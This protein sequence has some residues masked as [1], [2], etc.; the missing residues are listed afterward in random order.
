[1]PDPSQQSLLPRYPRS[2][3]LAVGALLLLGLLLRLVPMGRESLRGD[4][5]FTAS[6]TNLSLF[7]AVVAVLRFDV[8][9]PL[10]YLQVNLWSF[11]GH[12]DTWL[13][14]NP[15]F[16]GM[17]TLLLV[18]HI[19]ERRLGTRAGL[20]ALACCAVLGSEM[21]FTDE[22][23]PY[24]MVS[25]LM[26]LSWILADRVRA[27][28]RF[29]TA[30]PLMVTLIIVGGSHSFGSVETSAALLYIAPFGRPKEQ[31]RRELP[32]WLGISALVAFFTLPWLANASLR[33]VGHMSTVNLHTIVETVGGWALGYG[34]VPV[35]PELQTLVACAIALIV[36]YAIRRVPPLQRMILC[37]LLWVLTFTAVA[38]VLWKPIWLF[39]P[40]SYCAP[41][42]AIVFGG[43]ANE[44]FER[45]GRRP[46]AIAQ[47][48]AMGGVLVILLAMG[49]FSV[50]QSTTPRKT[51]Y[52]LA[53]TYLREHV[54]PGDIIYAP[55]PMTFWGTARY[56]IG[57]QWGNLLKVQDPINQ[58]QSKFWPHTYERL[59][60]SGWLA[61]LHLKPQTRRADG[62]KA[63]LYIG[64]SPLPEIKKAPS[65]WV[66]IPTDMGKD[67]ALEAM[68]LP[69]PYKTLS[70][71]Q[72][73]DLSIAH[74][75]C[76]PAEAPATTT[77]I[78]RR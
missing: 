22:L 48:S 32:T 39:R 49:W 12:S 37:Y 64:W 77:A 76:L 28:Y 72:F 58:D 17:I 44:I 26:L 52:G 66:M 57:P 53:A 50:L 65:T 75:T 8:H 31:F 33:H 41:F 68:A 70:T 24:T 73:L 18:F 16:W 71:E 1:M 6:Y 30:I 54:Q 14:L 45:T 61:W 27:D 5:I 35:S 15:I 60:A 19:A 67:F 21:Y 56:L 2:T 59:D 40:F 13:M 23:R 34:K 42:M 63:P 46:S 9:P 3:Q 36:V 47:R 11:L 38:S 51:Q 43:V 4:E 69:C 78:S 20:L 74:I 29:Q 55:N 62:F 25:S 7:D 10:Y